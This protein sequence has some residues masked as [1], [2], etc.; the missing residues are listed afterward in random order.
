MQNLFQARLITQ[1]FAQTGTLR[2]VEQAMH[3]GAAQIGIDQQR[4]E[5]GQGHADRQM[6][7]DQSFALAFECAAD[8]DQA[9]GLG[10]GSMD[11]HGARGGDRLRQQIL[12]V[13]GGFLG[14][15]YQGRRG[16]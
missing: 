7:R 6:A 5:T 11:Q 8:Q 10:F 1:Q 2:Q 9:K 4:L 16:T 14:L 15:V 3:N 12:P 13:F